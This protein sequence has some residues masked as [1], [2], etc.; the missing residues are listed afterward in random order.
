VDTFGDGD[1]PLAALRPG[2]IGIVH[3]IVGGRMACVRLRELG[4]CPN[5][6]VQVVS[7]YPNGSMIVE[8]SGCRFALGRGMAAKVGMRKAA[9]A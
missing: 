8:V 9:E 5:A 6:H 4:F 2:E 1:I 3:T 7:I